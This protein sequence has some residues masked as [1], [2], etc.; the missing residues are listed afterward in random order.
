MGY[1][2]GLTSSRKI[3]QACHEN[4]VFM[5]L[6]C[7]QHPDHSTISTFVSSMKEEIMPLFR[8]VLLICEELKLLG[9]TLFALDGCKLACNAS[10]QWSRTVSE[11][12]EKRV[13]LEERV[14]E[15]LKEQEDEDR[16]DADNHYRERQIEKLKKQADRIETWLKQ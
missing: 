2:R 7:R 4:V 3:E 13:K 14:K 9:G 1:S 11:L 10:P 6:S 5:A 16:K 15:L 12:K 8:D